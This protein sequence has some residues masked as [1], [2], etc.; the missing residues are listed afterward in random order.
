MF[1]YSY[2]FVVLLFVLYIYLLKY[3]NII[4]NTINY[5]TQEIRQIGNKEKQQ[6]LEEIIKSKKT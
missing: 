5:K 3:T 2:Y 4:R 6:K 1:F